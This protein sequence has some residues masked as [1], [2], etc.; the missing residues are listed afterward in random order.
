M[1]FEAGFL[2][3]II[4]Q[5][6][7][8]Q[9]L[10]F[11]KRNYIFFLQKMEEH[12]MAYADILAYCLMPNHFH[13]MVCVNTVTSAIDVPA[14]SFNNQEKNTHP[15][16]LRSLNDSIGIMLRSYTRAVN[17]QQKSSGSLFREET[18]AYCLNKTNKLSLLWRVE[19]GITC[20]NSKSEERQYPNMCYN[21]IACNP[22]KAGLVK[23]LQDWKF[24]S[25][26]KENSDIR[27]RLINRDRVKEYGLVLLE[28]FGF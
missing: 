9:N 4:N 24:S 15:L 16:K 28:N 22:M 25:F 21:Y 7:N 12:I 5:G 8:K 17:K 10:F 26:T 18:K 23:N 20:M 11:S 13:I 3:H 6:N 2:Y 1:H 27:D 19:N 14:S